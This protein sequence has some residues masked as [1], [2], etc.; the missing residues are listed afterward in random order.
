MNRDTKTEPSPTAEM[1][2]DPAPAAAPTSRGAQDPAP[3]DITLEGLKLEQPS[4]ET[5]AAIMAQH[6]PD[7]RGAGYIK[8]YAIA[9]SVFLCSTMSGTC[10]ATIRM[11][12]F[13]LS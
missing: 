3:T 1:A 10:R 13:V 9:G 7:M 11:T 5:Y 4:A 6:R 8:L 12:C 2:A